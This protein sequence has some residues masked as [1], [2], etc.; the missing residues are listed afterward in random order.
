MHLWDK[1]WEFNKNFA[2]SIIL[3]QVG[4]AHSSPVSPRQFFS[5]G[6]RVCNIAVNGIVQYHL[7]ETTH[8]TCC[9][10][11]LKP[12]WSNDPRDNNKSRWMAQN[13]M[14]LFRSSEFS[15]QTSTNFYT[16]QPHALQINRWENRTWNDKTKLKPIAPST[17]HKHSI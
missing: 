3:K 16:N 4:P 14:I 10:Q 11:T 12:R 17:K 5:P 13:A 1:R 8:H 15:D 2:V 7:R 9:L 6:Y